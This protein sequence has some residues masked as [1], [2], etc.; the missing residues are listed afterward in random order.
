MSKELIIGVRNHRIL[1]NLLSVYIISTKAEKGHYKI[2]ES[3]SITNVEKYDFEF[4]SFHKQLVK[5][6][7]EY[8][9]LNLIRAFSKKKVTSQEFYKGLNEKFIQEN[10]RVYIEKRIL[11]CFEIIIQEKIK[12]YYK[13]D[14]SDAI[15]PDDEI[16]VSSEPAETIFNFIKT[17]NS[18]KYFLTIRHENKEISLSDKAA[19]ELVNQPCLIVIENKL[20]RFTDIDYKK[21]WP[22]F[23]KKYI[24][25]PETAIEKYMASFVMNSIRHFKVNAEGF[26]IIPFSATPKLILSLELD[27]LNEP[28]II[29]YF[30]YDQKQFLPGDSTKVSVQMIK[31]KVNGKNEYTFI[32]TARKKDW[33]EK[34]VQLLLEWGLKKVNDNHFKY[35]PSEDKSD[36]VQFGTFNWVNQH[37]PKFDELGIELIQNFDKKKYFTES[38]QVKLQ[39]K[40]GKRKNSNNI[41]WFEVHAVVKFGE[42]EVPFIKLRKYILD[43][44]REF[45]LPSGEIAILPEHWFIEYKDLMLWGK[46]FHGA[47][48]LERC[49]YPIL[50]EIKALEYIGIDRDKITQIKSF[51]SQNDKVIIDPP[52]KIQAHLRPYQQEGYSWMMSLLKNGFGGCLADD[53]GLGKTLQTLTMLVKCREAFFENKSTLPDNDS[54][55]KEMVFTNLIVV[56]TS[57]IHNWFNE[58][59]KFSPSMK[60]CIY[61]G[62][63]RSMY[64][65][66]FSKYDIVITSYGLVR[67]DLEIMMEYSFFCIVLDE[68]QY[69]KNHTSKI[70]QAV[71]ELRAKNKFILTGTPIENSLSDLWSQMNFI[72]EGFLGSFKFF[73]DQF[74]Y[75]I[76]KESSEKQQKKLINMIHPF[77]LRRTKQEVAND[78]PELSEQT[79]FCDMSEKQ[80]ELYILEKSKIRNALADCMNEKSYEKVAF[81]ALQG[82]TRLRQLANHPLMIMDDYE[83][84]SGKFDEVL[85][86]LENLIAENHKVILFSSFVRHLKIFARYFETKKWKY[87]LLTGQT[88]NR[89]SVIKSF[90]ENENNKLFLISLKAGGVG[91]NLTAADY[92]FI[93]DP[94]WNPAAEM[95]AISRV[96]RIGQEKHVFVYRFISAET[97]EEKILALKERKAHL[98]NAFINTNNPFKSLS[99]EEIN[100]IFD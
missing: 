50:D 33:E 53:M 66:S 38:I 51:L 35:V 7:N 82:L 68:S 96:H 65:K 99:P 28:V 4:T 44:I 22:F 58:I 16:I 71:M 15:Y 5:I 1:G 88:V 97:I 3:I 13:S 25:V 57:L 64:A 98:A 6:I 42:F 47:L 76:E 72:N 40:P 2:L 100:E 46:E 56:P 55:P 75:P 31:N 12:V 29:P 34:S 94:W 39:L 73:K 86:N 91:L 52:K 93:L 41:D 90:M 26:D 67:N 62:N 45:Y 69:I 20:Y 89:E 79:V 77:I 95:Q 85:T 36:F 80:S 59:R 83:H 32:K 54:N 18:L 21:L 10:L 87:S 24:P 37:K 43:G 11:R 60:I 8:S 70:W 61:S 17:Q 92:V 9:D 14:R 30:H 19:Q 23:L 74:I 48:R 63:E 84:N 81:L 78:L 27:W 49:F